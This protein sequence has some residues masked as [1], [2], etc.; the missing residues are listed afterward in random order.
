[1][2]ESEAIARLKSGDIAG[3]ETLVKLYQER[4]LRASYL[5]SYDYALAEDV[6]QGA[7]LR[8]YERISQ[9]DNSR[10]FG[11]WFLRSVVNDTLM[12]VTR[13]RTV[14][15]DALPDPENASTAELETDVAQLLEAA[16]TRE[17]VWR[18]IGQLSPG[19]RAAVVM[20]YYLDLSD[21]EA[22]ARLAVPPGT[23][24]RRLHDARERLRHLLPAWIAQPI[25]E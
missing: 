25:E 17:A 1:M 22:A 4:A 9:F 11:P 21:T 2:K 23:I 3:L 8:A 16:E 18:A 12:A 14:P 20:R 13:R 24:R 10:S 15:V 5:I 7:F 6:V 19:Q